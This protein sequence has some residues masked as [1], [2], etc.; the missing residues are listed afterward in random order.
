MTASASTWKPSHTIL[1]LTCPGW[2]VERKAYLSL[3]GNTLVDIDPTTPDTLWLRNYASRLTRKEDIN[4]VF[5][6]RA[7]LDIQLAQDAL[8]Q[9]FFTLAELD[10][11]ARAAPSEKFIGWVSVV[12]TEINLSLLHRRNMLLCGTHC[13]FPMYANTPTIKCKQCS[14]DIALRLNPKILGRV[15]DETACSAAG[16][17]YLSDDAWEQL[18]GRSMQDLC[19]VSVDE[20]KFLQQRMLYLRVNLGLAWWAEENEA[21]VGRVWVWAVKA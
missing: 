13:G 2:R 17:L 5:P 11:F 10:E 9:I 21:G 3:T 1:L 15:V 4:P 16:K 6:S 7:Q 19:R 8:N 18:L 20:L 12:L 14:A